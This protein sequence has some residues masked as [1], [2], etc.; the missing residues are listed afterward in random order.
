MQEK[1]AGY[2]GLSQR[3]NLLREVVYNELSTLF[4]KSDYAILGRDYVVSYRTLL[5]DFDV[6]MKV[7]LKP[8]GARLLPIKIDYDGNWHIPFKERERVKFTAQFS[9]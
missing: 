3:A 5:F 4:R 7:R 6:R 8:I 9:Y 1:A 2:S